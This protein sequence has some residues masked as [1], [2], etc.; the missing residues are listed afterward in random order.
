MGFL[1]SFFELFKPKH[2]FKHA[3]DE[4]EWQEGW[5][6]ELRNSFGSDWLAREKET[7][8]LFG[9][10]PECLYNYR[11]F[12]GRLRQYKTYRDTALVKCPPDDHY[13][14]RFRVLHQNGVIKKIDNPSILDKLS[15]LKMAELR[16]IAKKA[17]LKSPKMRDDLI[18][19][20]VATEGVEDHISN[21]PYDHLYKFEP[22]AGQMNI[23]KW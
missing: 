11:M 19:L 4:Q 5:E 12:C 8:R 23:D 6:A 3:E 13:F 10:K 7:S 17:G 15:L 21:G 9:G 20:L 1:D 14:A 22:L 2:K 16:D 18:D